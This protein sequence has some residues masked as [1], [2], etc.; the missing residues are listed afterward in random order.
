MLYRVIGVAL[1]TLL[2]FILVS[3]LM[4]F[5]WTSSWV[6]FTGFICLIIILFIL[7]VKHLLSFIHFIKTK[8]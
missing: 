2:N 4:A 3:Y 6:K 1:H 5:D 7:F 8:A